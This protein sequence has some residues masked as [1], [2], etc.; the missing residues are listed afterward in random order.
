MLYHIHITY[1]GC[2]Y[3]L[4]EGWQASDHSSGLC[5]IFARVTPPDMWTPRKKIQCLL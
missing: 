4:A 2:S 5:F 1:L 3:R